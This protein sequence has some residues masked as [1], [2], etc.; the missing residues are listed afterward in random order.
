MPHD[1]RRRTPTAF[2]DIDAVRIAEGN[3]LVAMQ[4]RPWDRGQQLKNPDEH[5]ERLVAERKRAQQHRG[6]DRLAKAAPIRQGFLRRLAEG[7]ETLAAT[8]RAYSSYSTS[9]IRWCADP[10]R[11]AA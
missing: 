3:E 1:R 7:N 5:L 2:A 10:G 11:E 4:A 9:R 6:L 8:R